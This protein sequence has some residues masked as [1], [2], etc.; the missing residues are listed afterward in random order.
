MHVTK[1]EQTPTI[2]T[3]KLSGNNNLR[4][5]PG[6]KQLTFLGKC[7]GLSLTGVDARQ[8]DDVELSSI[9][10]GEIRSAAVTDVPFDVQLLTA[11][12]L[13]GKPPATD[14]VTEDDET[15]ILLVLAL[16]HIHLCMFITSISRQI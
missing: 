11:V 2:V 10:D 9:S 13:T 1:D 8:E 5:H 3:S 15:T 12:V 7:T 16:Q 14:V 6:S 4:L